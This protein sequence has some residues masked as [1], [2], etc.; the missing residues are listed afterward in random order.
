MC[1]SQDL[2]DDVASDGTLA[3]GHVF[4]DLT[5]KGDG[6]ADGLKVDANG[7]LFAT[8]PGGVIVFAPD[9]THLGTLSTGEA[10]SNCAWGEDGSTLFITADQYL[11]RIKTATKGNKF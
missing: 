9:G 4:A 7:N 5:G 6:L 11:V 2:F 1:L 8:G 10:T 3:G